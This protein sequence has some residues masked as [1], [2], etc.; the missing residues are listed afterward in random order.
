MLVAQCL[1]TEAAEVKL[2]AVRH[3]KKERSEKKDHDAGSG[4]QDCDEKPFTALC[5]YFSL[6]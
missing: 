1:T 6:V 2:I 5:H 4:N 3:A